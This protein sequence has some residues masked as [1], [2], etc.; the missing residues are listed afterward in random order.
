MRGFGFELDIA[1]GRV[2]NWY[3]GEDGVQRWVDTDQPCSQLTRLEE[4]FAKEFGLPKIAPPDPIAQD[5]AVE[6][7][8]AMRESGDE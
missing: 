4:D 2:R 7:V 6:G 1:S 5:E 8:C 3:S